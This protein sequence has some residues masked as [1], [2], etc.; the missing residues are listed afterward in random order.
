M[1]NFCIFVNS[2][3]TYVKWYMYKHL[4]ALLQCNKWLWWTATYS[5]SLILCQL[6][7]IAIHY[8]D[9]FR[10]TKNYDNKIKKFHCYSVLTH[11]YIRTYVWMFC[12]INKYQ[13]NMLAM[14]SP[15][16][17]NLKR[18][19]SVLSCY[20]C[21]ITEMPLVIQRML[22][23]PKK[24]VYQ[25]VSYIRGSGTCKIYLGPDMYVPLK[26]T[27]LWMTVFSATKYQQCFNN[28]SLYMYVLVD[29]LLCRLILKTIT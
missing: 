7:I 22:H 16:C 21:R 5:Y 26:F 19:R 29:L 18:L 24:L 8:R 28:E 3:V 11:T 4:K 2:C 17:H 20:W 25:A 15:A 10:V 9:I 27:I 1:F 14:S 23:K 13:Q 6:S 12:H